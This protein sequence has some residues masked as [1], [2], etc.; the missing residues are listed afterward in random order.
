VTPHQ[1][2]ALGVRLF[3][4][5]Y[6]LVIVREVLGFFTMRRPPE[7]PQTLVVVIGGSVVSFVILLILWFFPKSIARGLLPTST[8][9]PTQTLSYQRWFSLGTALLGLWFVAS[10]IAPMLRN[11]S[12][13]YVFRP[14]LMSAEVARSL[15]VGLF[16]YF[17]EMVLG[18]CLLFGA[19]GISKLISRLRH[20]G[21]G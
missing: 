3:A 2:L 21:S 16:Y 9:A 6:A 5:W 17:A 1:A 20:A 4:V 7:D 8:D 13:M 10:S 18:L 19:T 15:R 12:V 11:L 14:E